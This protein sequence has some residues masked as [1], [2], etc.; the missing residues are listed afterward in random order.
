MEKLFYSISEVAE[1][2]G[3]SVPCVRFWTNENPD[4]VSPSRSNKGNR[5]YR[6]EDIEALKKI[7]FLVRNEGL[8]LDGA[9][10]RMS[11]DGA[12]VDKRVK[13]LE[14]LKRIRQQLMEIK[15]TL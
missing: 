12:R 1:I 14:S 5:Q 3:E 15:E 2:L 9:A 4:A 13:A 6:K 7:R 10:R 8:T 11:A